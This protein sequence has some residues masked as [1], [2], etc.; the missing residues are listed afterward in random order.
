MRRCNTMSLTSESAG[1][2]AFPQ[3]RPG[4]QLER[5]SSIICFLRGRLSGQTGS[6]TCPHV[7]SASTPGKALHLGLFLGFALAPSL[8][9]LWD[10][11]GGAGLSTV[12]HLVCMP[13]TTHGALSQCPQVGDFARQY[14]AAERINSQAKKLS[15]GRSKLYNGPVIARQNTL[16]AL[17]RLCQQHS[18]SSLLVKVQRHVAH[19]PA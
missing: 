11:D 15:T 18:S 5:T 6:T 9:Y 19:C 1:L 2:G 17:H 4:D 14:P 10:F 12:R 8:R 3:S 16:W 7:P 13:Y